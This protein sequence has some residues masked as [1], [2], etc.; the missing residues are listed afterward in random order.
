GV[1]LESGQPRARNPYGRGTAS[2]DSTSEPVD[3]RR[4]EALRN[5]SRDRGDEGA[6]GPAAPGS[7]AAGPPGFVVREAPPPQGLRRVD[8]PRREPR[9]RGALCE[10]AGR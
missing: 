1:T 2:I 3:A 10:I 9:V 7:D 4:R 5:V 6:E 8:D